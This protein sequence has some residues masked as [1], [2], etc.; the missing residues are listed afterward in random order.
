MYR[1][2]YIASDTTGATLKI[3][4]APVDEIKLSLVVISWMELVTQKIFF[5][6][7]AKNDK[8]SIQTETSVAG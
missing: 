8:T 1:Q 4:E 2:Q 6:L 3:D 7:L 5:V